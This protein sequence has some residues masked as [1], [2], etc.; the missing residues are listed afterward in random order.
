MNLRSK[1][2]SIQAL[3]GIAATLVVFLHICTVSSFGKNQWGATAYNFFLHF[4]AFGVD[5]FFVVSGVIIAGLLQQQNAGH[6]FYS[7]QFLMRRFVRIYPIYWLSLGATIVVLL[8]SGGL[9]PVDFSQLTPKTLGL[10]TTNFLHPVSW[11]LCFEIQFYL[12]AGLAMLFGR[13]SGAVIAVWGV[14]HIVAV[15]AAERGWGHGLYFAAPITVEFLPGLLIGYVASRRS[16]PFPRVC[17]VLGCVIVA[18]AGYYAGP[19]LGTTTG[20]LRLAIY[21]TAASLIVWGALSLEGAGSRPAKWV[22]F[23]GDIPYSTYMWHWPTMIAV[24]LLFGAW[25]SHSA[26]VLSYIVTTGVCVLMVSWASYRWIERPSTRWAGG[27]FKRP[28]RSG[29]MAASS[30]VAAVPLPA[31]SERLAI[32]QT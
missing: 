22:T 2:L 30:P 7:L 12:V 1:S 16:L 17:I 27:L 6:P 29:Q 14:A 21:G 4:G 32:R 24:S 8:S 31:L 19:M 10:V 20:L 15:T 18:V 25:L 9:Y 11:T 26:G 3:R 13:R 5:I 28:P 23:L